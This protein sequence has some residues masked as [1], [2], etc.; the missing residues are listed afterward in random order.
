M[1]GKM[2]W[3]LV[4]V[5]FVGV[6]GFQPAPA[7]AEFPSGWSMVFFDVS[8]SLMDCID[9]A[10]TGGVAYAFLAGRSASCTAVDT[11]EPGRS[12]LSCTWRNV[13]W[14]FFA[15]NT[16]EVI[17]DVTCSR[18]GSPFFGFNGFGAGSCGAAVSYKRLDQYGLNMTFNE[19]YSA[20]TIGARRKCST[21]FARM[22][23]EQMEN[24]DIRRY[25]R[26]KR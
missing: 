4:A 13:D 12:R 16:R 2:S 17:I 5:L 24:F 3:L 26:R 20:A 1:R 22:T 21:I 10:A 14:S 7:Q 9:F 15:P 8:G 23:E 25:I 18:W 6:L 19:G 11:F